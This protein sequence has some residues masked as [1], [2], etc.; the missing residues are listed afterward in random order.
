MLHYVHQLAVTNV[1][2]LFGAAM[3]M[4]NQFVI[5]Q[6][7]ELKGHQSSVEPRGADDGDKYKK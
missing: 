4:Y 7:N 2:S 6:N 3:V 5:V 1:C